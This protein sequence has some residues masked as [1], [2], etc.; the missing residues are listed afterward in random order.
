[1]RPTVADAMLTAPKVCGPDA[2]VADLRDLFEDDHVHCALLADGRRLVSVVERPDLA[3]ASGEEPAARFGRLEGRT[4]SA[5]DDLVEAHRQM[6]AERVRRLAVVDDGELVGLLC[7]KKSGDGFCT[8]EGVAARAAE[9]AGGARLY[10]ATPFDAVVLAGGQASRMGGRDKTAMTVGGIAIVERVL[11]SVWAAREVVVVGPEVDGGPVAALAS[12]LPQLEEDVV[13][14]LAGDMPFVGGAIHPLLTAL[15][16]A[17]D[18][19]HAAVLVADGRRQHLAA[20][21]RRS[22]L[23]WRLSA[24]PPR[25]AA[26]RALFTDQVVEVPDAGGWSLDIDTPED[27][28]AARTSTRARS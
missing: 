13:V 16:A 25:N 28:V 12:A 1:M 18:D 23:A 17:P 11:A 6:V 15:A 7:L 8:E 22:A 21:W 27:L 5:D 2:S 20:A 19:T 10:A 24:L 4:I 14:T 3:G 26:M 9:R